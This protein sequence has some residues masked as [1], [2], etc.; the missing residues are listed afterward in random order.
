MA[1]TG[2]LISSGSLKN[3][4]STMTEMKTAAE[5][6]NNPKIISADGSFKF[7]EKYGF[8]VISLIE[9]N[10]ENETNVEIAINL[11][12]DGTLSTVFVTEETKSSDVINKI[13]SRISNVTISEL[14]SLENISEEDVKNNNDYLSIMY[15]NLDKIKKETYQ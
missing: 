1:E 5:S 10:K 9:D 15:N 13:K 4:D 14:N 12:S 11:L 8:E 6:S 3:K 2:T 7:L